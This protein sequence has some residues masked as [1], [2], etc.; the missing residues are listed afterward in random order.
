MI[1]ELKLNSIFTLTKV[2]LPIL[3]SILMRVH[4]SAFYWFFLS[5]RFVQIYRYRLHFVVAVLSELVLFCLFKFK[6]TNIL[7]IIHN[8]DDIERLS[9]VSCTDCNYYGLPFLGYAFQVCQKKKFCF[10]K[11]YT[12][13]R[14]DFPN[15][16][17]N[18]ES[19]I[20]VS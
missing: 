11:Y 3:P 17:F 4:G 9:I 6:E 5:N 8:K 16:W 15:C 20:N 12:L 13:P 2:H 14:I 18:S 7:P 10:L 1:W 19:A